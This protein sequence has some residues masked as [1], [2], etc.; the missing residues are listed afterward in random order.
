MTKDEFYALMD[1]SL[2]RQ[3]RITKVLAVIG[4]IFMA[5]GL[6]AMTIRGDVYLVFGGL[7]VFM[8]VI[9]MISWAVEKITHRSERSHEHAKSMIATTPAEM[10]W[11]YHFIQRTNGAVSNV[12]A[13]I[14]FRG[15]IGVDIY[16]GLLPGKDV[17]AFLLGLRALNPAVRLGYTKELERMYRKGLM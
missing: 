1:A 16:Y 14:R 4:G 17:P 6:V 7:G 11:A 3:K 2:A 10:L 15:G 13:R 5:A 8:G 12:E 9:F